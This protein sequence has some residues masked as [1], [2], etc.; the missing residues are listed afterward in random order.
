MKTIR[1]AREE[2][3]WTQL[4]LANRLKVTPATIYNWER[5]RSEPRASQ[6]R[7]LAH[8]FGISL[9]ELVLTS[10]G[11]QEGGTAPAREGEEG[12]E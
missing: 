4:E 2:L 8:L 5:G 7:Q 10:A 3:G 11:R 12:M 6:F 9:D 1:Q